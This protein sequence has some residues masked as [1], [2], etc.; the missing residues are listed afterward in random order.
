MNILGPL[1]LG[2]IAVTLFATWIYALISAIKN[3]RL[4]STMRLTWVIVIIFVTGIGA[5]LYLLI[6]PN[7]PR[8]EEQVLDEWN[9]RQAR[10][11]H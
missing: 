11:R 10:M 9:R 3:E 5:L 8:P 7:R 4:D 1:L 6:A 2:A